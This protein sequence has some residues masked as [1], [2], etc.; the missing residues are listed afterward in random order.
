MSHRICPLLL[1][2]FI[3]SIYVIVYSLATKSVPL[4][5]YTAFSVLCGA[6]IAFLLTLSS[7]QQGRNFIYLSIVI[8]ALVLWNFHTI[9]TRYHLVAFYDCYQELVHLKLILTNGH[10]DIGARYPELGVGPGFSPDYPLFSILASS[11]ALIT[12]LGPLNVGILLPSICGTLLF[13]ST[14]LFVRR[15]LTTSNVRHVAVPLALLMFAVSPD[16]VY[17]STHFYHRELSL[18]LCFLLLYFL[19]RRFLGELS[20]PS[21]LL[22]ML[23]LLVLPLTHSA[24]PSVYIVFTLSLAVITTLVHTL[25][26]RLKIFNLKTG[27]RP[28]LLSSITI[29]VVGFLWNFMLN[30]PSP[31]SNAF[32]GY[33]RDLL[34]PRYEVRDITRFQAEAA[35]VLPSVLRPEPWIFLL[36]LRDLMLIAPL[37]IVGLFL[38]YKLL[39]KRLN[40]GEELFA[41]LSMASFV[42]MILSDYIAGWYPLFF[43]YYAFPLVAYSA[44]LFYASLVKLKAKVAKGMVSI[45]VTFLVSMAFLSPFWHIYYPR[46]LYDPEVEWKEVGFPHPS[47]INFKDFIETHGPVDKLI[48]SDFRQLLITMLPIEKLNLIRCVSQHYGEHDTV[49][50]EFVGLNPVLGYGSPDIVEKMNSI[51]T[52]INSKYCRVL[53][54]KPYSMYYKP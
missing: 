21:A 2:V 28:V 48:L 1:C 37:P 30:Y 44:G 53:D 36:P 7:K 20:F 47:Y 50:V 17:A 16:M 34:S 54:S 45:I 5:L 26:K 39:R 23:L 35:P 25:N 14:L 4:W 49:I 3:A 12:G 29:F 13:L 9:A 27:M 24:Y 32:R 42:P 46:Q 10:V 8:L 40:E 11:F 41:L 33:L 18:G 38:L 52:S 6:S 43:R 31:V 22:L 19:V 15:L 51:R